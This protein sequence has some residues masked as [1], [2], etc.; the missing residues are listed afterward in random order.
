MSDGDVEAAAMLAS[1]GGVRGRGGL[2][3]GGRAP[4][5]V[6][7]SRR[8]WPTSRCTSS[9]RRGQ[10]SGRR[11]GVLVRYADDFVVLCPT[12]RRARR[13]NDGSGAVLAELGLRLHPDKTR[14]VCLAR[15]EEGFDFLGFHHRKVESWKWRGRWYLHRWPSDRA[16][17]LDPGQDPGRDRPPLRWPAEWATWWPTSTPCCGAGANYF[18]DGNSARKFAT[19]D[20]YVHLR[21]AISPAPNT[22]S[23][24]GTG[25]PLQP[26]LARQ[27]RR[28]PTRPER[29]A[30]R[31][32]HASR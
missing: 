20:S 14:I 31:T 8:C 30:T 21:I 6:R 9:M 25:E 13:P 24:D 17:E 10:T 29:C 7:P 15:G 4:R 32:A 23:A 28:L 11:L 19:I 27:P 1:G 16:M 12:R 18:R 3:Y 26:R 22:G 2:R 5:R